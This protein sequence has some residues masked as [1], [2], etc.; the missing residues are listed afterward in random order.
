M[1]I[2]YNTY[3]YVYIPSY[4]HIVCVCVCVCVY[5]INALSTSCIHSGPFSTAVPPQHKRTFTPPA[6]AATPRPYHGLPIMLRIRAT[7]HP[8]PQALPGLVQAALPWPSLLLSP[9]TRLFLPE[10]LRTALPSAETASNLCWARS[11]RV[12]PSLA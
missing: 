8:G 1:C 6:A 9:R 11:A 7:P 3:V 5:K 10:A 12:G 4:I 2:Y